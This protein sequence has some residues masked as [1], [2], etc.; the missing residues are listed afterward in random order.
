LFPS[1]CFESFKE[2]WNLTYLFDGQAQKAFFD[3]HGLAY[4]TLSVNGRC[5]FCWT[6]D[7]KMSTPSVSLPDGVEVESVHLTP[8]D[9]EGKGRAVRGDSGQ[10]R[11]G[12]P[13]RKFVPKKVQGI[14]IGYKCG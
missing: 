11:C 14:A 12:L 8:L 10:G 13:L 3:I 6:K 9:L 7:V 2:V 5:N 4:E 1:N